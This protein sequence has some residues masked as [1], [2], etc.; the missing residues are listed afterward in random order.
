MRNQPET[1]YA[2]ADEEYVAYQVFGDGPRATSSSSRRGR[3]T[4]T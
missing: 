4:S 1:N 3:R 2:K